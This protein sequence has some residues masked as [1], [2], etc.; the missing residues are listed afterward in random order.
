MRGGLG[1]L[2]GG[3]PRSLSLLWVRI[4][5]GDLITPAEPCPI[6]RSGDVTQQSSPCPALPTVSPVLSPSLLLGWQRW[7]GLCP[8]AACSEVN[9]FLWASMSSVVCFASSA[10][11]SCNFQPL[12]PEQD[13]FFPGRLRLLRRSLS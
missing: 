9:H 11:F 12:A 8:R 4:A 5:R 13:I 2:G 6:P 7:L 10:H 3:C 1:R